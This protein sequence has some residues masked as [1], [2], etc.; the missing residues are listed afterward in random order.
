MRYVFRPLG[1]WTEGDT[2]NRRGSHVFKASWSDTLNLLARELDYLEASNVVLQA[3][4]TEADVRLD[5]MLR[6]N[7]RV[8]H[9]GVRVAFNSKFGPLTYATDAYERWYSYGKLDGWQA[10][11]RAIALGLEALRA[12]DRYGVTR[13]GEQYTGWKALPSGNGESSHM[14]RQD[15]VRVI[16][17]AAEAVEN[18]AITPQVVR[19]A[20]ANAHPDR[21]DGR[22]ELWDVVE[23]A[24]A[25]LGRL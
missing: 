8:N 17:A 7:A 11:I 18:E 22:R 20:K 23:R 21:N 10:N 12:V 5:G 4:V 6:A 24:A 9:P 15:A 13:R 19:R 1:P 2:P 25:V 14:T 3:D 16:L